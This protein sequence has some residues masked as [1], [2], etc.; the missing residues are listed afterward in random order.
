[1]VDPENQP[2]VGGRSVYDYLTQRELLSEREAE[3]AREAVS[4]TKPASGGRVLAATL[5]RQIEELQAKI[6]ENEKK[7]SAL[8]EKIAAAEEKL[9]E[10]KMARLHQAYLLQAGFL[11]YAKLNPYNLSEYQ[12]EVV[13]SNTNKEIMQ[14]TKGMSKEEIEQGMVFI[15]QTES[16]LSLWRHQLERR[17]GTYQKL[18]LQHLEAKQK[19]IGGGSKQKQ[20][21]EGVEYGQK[22]PEKEEPVPI[23]VKK[24]SAQPSPE[25]KEEDR[26]AMQKKKPIAEEELNAAIGEYAELLRAKEKWRNLSVL[27]RYSEKQGKIKKAMRFLFGVR[28][29][30]DILAREAEIRENF[31]STVSQFLNQSAN[32]SH[33]LDLVYRK[34]RDGLNAEGRESGFA[35]FLRKLRKP[36]VAFARFLAGAALAVGAFLTGG[37]PGAIMLGAAGVLGAVGRFVAVD[38]I[39]DF[40]HS[41][42]STREKKGAYGMAGNVFYNASDRKM[43]EKVHKVFS[44]IEQKNADEVAEEIDG[45]FMKY[46][47]RIGRNRFWKRLAGL[48]AIAAPFVYKYFAAPGKETAAPDSTKPQTVQ[49]KPV[50]PEPKPPEQVPQIEGSDIYTVKPGGSFWSMSKE[51]LHDKL[52]EHFDKLPTAEKNAMI[53]ALSKHLQADMAGHDITPGELHPYNGPGKPWLNLYDKFDGHQTDIKF[54][55][56]HMQE[57]LKEY[58]QNG[59]KLPKG[60]SP[61][62]ANKILSNLPGKTPLKS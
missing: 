62:T 22:A 17:E 33:D 28:H 42:I 43:S 29:D 39:W 40:L 49:P 13:A 47:N 19:A 11:E 51:I 21:K 60:I 35:R 7:I 38:G 4:P 23:E 57:F 56:V 46:A 2:S 36:A 61:E 30:N 31:K 32:R 27:S 20:E 24:E 26:A 16:Q 45:S 25:Q 54:T 5:Q 8:R 6:A 14:L 48:A 58:F 9:S 15:E 53:N 41:K 18:L 12:L 34:I 52:G 37:L 59:K 44:G 1:M 10:P 55:K 3:E 50:E